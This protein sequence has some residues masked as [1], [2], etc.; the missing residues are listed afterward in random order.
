MHRQGH[1]GIVL[2][3]LAPVLYVLF[4]VDRPLLALVACSIVLIEPLPD[5][6]F[7]VP[8][9]SHRGMSHSLVAAGIIGLCCAGFGWVIGTY[10]TDTVANWLLETIVVGPLAIE[11]V[12]TH[13]ATLDAGLLIVVGFCLGSGGICL[14]LLGD[15]ITRGGIRPYLPFSRRTVS[16]T[17]LY[18]NNRLVNRGLFGS[19]V[20]AMVALGL[21]LTPLGDLL[22][23]LLDVLW[24]AVVTR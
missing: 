19:G 17:P 5:N 24:Q 22:V 3:A 9:L 10:I 6:D 11:W 18:A 14:H 13:L 23:E 12:K 1:F 4:S 20:L 15:V 2:L 8:G 16:L 7:W 21:V